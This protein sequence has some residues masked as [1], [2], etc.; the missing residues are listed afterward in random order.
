MQSTCKKLGVTP[1]SVF[2]AAWAIVLHQYTRS[3]HVMFGSVMSG[4]DTGLDGVDKMVGMLINTVP[5]QVH[6]RTSKLLGDLIVDVHGLSTDLVQ[7]SHC[8]LVDVKRW[9]NLSLE[10]QLFDSIMVYQNYPPSV[11]DKSKPRPF[12]LEFQ[13]SE[14]FVDSAVGIAIGASGDQYFVRLT[15]LTRDIDSTIADFLLER[16]V[17]VAVMLTS[18]Q[19][20]T[21]AS[22]DVPQKREQLL[23][24]SSCFGPQVPLQYELLHHAFEE[25]AKLNPNLHAIEFEGK[26][27]TY[28]ELDARANALAAD[29]AKMGV[30]VGDRVAVVMDRCLEFPVG[31]LAT[32][33]VG[34][35]MIPMDVLFPDSRLKFMLTDANVVR[36]IS[37]EEHG[38]RIVQLGLSS[39]VSFIDIVETPVT[40]ILSATYNENAAKSCHEAYIVYTSGSTGK[41]KGVPVLHA[42]AVNVMLNHSSQVGFVQGNRVMQFMAIGFDGFQWDLWKSLSNGATLVFRSNLGLAELCTVDAI[43]CTPTAL[44]LLGHPSQYPKLS[45]VSVA[46]EACP[47][48]LKDLWLPYVRFTNL[49]GPSECAIM[50]HYKELLQNSTV[51]IGKPISNTNSYILDCNQ[52]QLPVGVVGEIYLGGI[53]VSPYYINLP[54]H[55]AE[56]FFHDPFIGGEARMFRTGDLG[57]L[58]PDGNFEILGRQDSQV[59]LKGYRIELDEVAEAMLLHPGVISAAAIVKDKTHLVGYFTPA[60]I[61]IPMLQ[62]T[63]ESH[64]PFY[65]V[66]A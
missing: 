48:A 26:S 49:Y 5:I 64:L 51:T 33:K 54:E 21:V 16:F 4:R 32:L 9:A 45:C 31:L 6:V 22:L 47:S 34:A 12:S 41:P 60:D 1:S 40:A 35:V 59:K 63:V 14:E 39:N 24:E 61:S 55:T 25:K 42:S 15:H 17:H 58:L 30:C 36:I 11:I 38:S 43:T 52:V 50:T 23:L 65:M 46:G 56:R 18:S 13:T 7:H 19:S 57:R 37:L 29:L 8:S 20:S 66:P 28:G 2:R 62:Q 53:C 10:G 27:L 3:E 44:S